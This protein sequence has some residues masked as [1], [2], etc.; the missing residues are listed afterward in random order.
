MLNTIPLREN[1]TDP[2]IT[3]TDLFE[4]P[5][6]RVLTMKISVAAALANFWLKPE[7]ELATTLAE[8]TPHGFPMRS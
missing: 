7:L 2:N 8:P 1:R 5:H 4:A 6:K 3:H